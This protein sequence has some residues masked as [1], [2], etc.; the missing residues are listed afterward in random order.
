MRIAWFFLLFA[1]FA[2]GCPVM[3]QFTSSAPSGE[4]KFLKSNLVVIET[5][6]GNG[7]GS[8]IGRKNNTYFV[9]TSRHVIDG[10]AKNEDID[11][12]TGDGNIYSG[13]IVTKSSRWDIA[14]VSFK[15]QKCYAESY[16]G[17]E[18]V[19]WHSEMTAQKQPGRMIIAGITAVDPAISKKP[20][21]RSAVASLSIKIDPEDSIDG[22]EFG[23]D[24]PTARGMSGGALLTDDMNINWKNSCSGECN[25]PYGYHLGVHGRGERDSIRG[26]AK[27]G[28]N[29]A[30]PSGYVLPLM[31]KGK[32]L[33][34]L[35][36]RKLYINQIWRG[37]D[38]QN[39]SSYRKLIDTIN[40]NNYRQFKIDTSSC[41][42]GGLIPVEF[43]EN[44]KNKILMGQIKN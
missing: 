34:A 3:A 19:S 41:R 25:N 10:I 22:F 27:T 24:A 39:T 9:L 21:I 16:I 14:I 36:T 7:S 18:T 31:K 28:Y 32:L 13:S 6:L 43:I 1:I 11:I 8:I 26:N 30:V 12:T 29:F 2:G 20:I 35:N 37:V 5:A 44:S 42:P 17:Y 38:L 4:R 33:T 15:S 23:Y 40:H